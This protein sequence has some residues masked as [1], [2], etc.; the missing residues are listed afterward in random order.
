MRSARQSTRENEK[1]ADQRAFVKLQ[2]FGG[3][4]ERAK[5]LE[6]STPT[7]ARSCSTTELHPR[8]R[9]RR[10]LAVNG[11]PMPNA[12]RECNSPHTAW[13]HRNNPISL[14]IG[15]KS[16]RNDAQSGFIEV[17]TL[18]REKEGSSC[19]RVAER[20]EPFLKRALKGSGQ[21]VPPGGFAVERRPPFDERPAAIGNW[22]DPQGGLIVG[23]R[24]GRRAAEFVALRP[25]DV[26]LRQQPLTDSPLL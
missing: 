10:S 24:H 3:N 2:H 18:R 16:V 7:L 4:L 22:R 17:V 5:G 11:R 23:H 15:R 13:N 12:D 14:T 1:P 8:P 26:G 6:P 19:H 20:F 9:W 25:F 21:F